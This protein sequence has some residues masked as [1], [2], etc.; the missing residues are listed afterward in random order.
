[1]AK[2]D[3]KVS[4][5]SERNPSSRDPE[6]R[7]QPFLSVLLAG[8]V[9]VPALG[10]LLRIIIALAPEVQWLTSGLAL[11]MGFLL[12]AIAVAVGIKVAKRLEFVVGHVAVTAVMFGAALYITSVVRMAPDAEEWY[13]RLAAAFWWPSWWV[14][15]HLFGSIV[16]AGS[17]LLY[18]IDAFRAATGTAEDTSGLGRLMSRWPKGAKIRAETIE[19]DEFAI[20]AEIDHEGVPIGELRAQLPALEE[21]P[22]FLRGRGSMVGDAKGGKTT[23][24]LVHTDPH[25]HW[26]P[27]PGLSHPGQPYHA[28]LRTSYYSDGKIQWYSFVKTPDGFRSQLAP[29]FASPN[30][31]FK[32]AQGM[33]GAGKSGDAAIECAE[34]L[35]RPDVVL[36]YVDPAK[37]MQNAAWCIDMCALAAGSPQASGV[38]FAGLQRMGEYRERVLSHHEIRDFSHEAF[39]KTGL[40]W[41]HI[42]ADEFDVARQSAAM[43]W[44][45]TKGRSLGFRFSFTLPRATGDNLDTN[46][47]A[48]V[49]MWAQFGI[50]QDYDDTFV[51]SKETR[52]AGADAEQFGAA[53]PGAHYLDHAPGVDKSRWPIDCRTYKTRDDFADLRAAVVAARAGFTPARLTQGELDAFGPEVAILLP[54]RIRQSRAINPADQQKQAQQA[55]PRDDPEPTGGREYGQ[56]DDMDTEV[57]KDVQALMEGE[58]DAD[59]DAAALEAEY[60]SLDTRAPLPDSAPDTIGMPSSKPVV[61]AAETVAEME[62]AIIRMDERNV[63]EFTSAD[64]RAEMRVAMRQAAMSKRFTAIQNDET[65]NP[66]GLLVKRMSSGHFAIV[67]VGNHGA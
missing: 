8:L 43:T 55:P 60:G 1:M 53:V 19:A 24:R 56:E 18:R 62:A 21:S 17:W 44:L 20:T 35:S 37:L 15:I 49:G 11:S 57:D 31:S 2:S 34:V 33:T 7:S 64:L 12:A 38:L 9:A 66:P 13:R 39:L 50:S 63:Q 67:R 6:K 25:S 14:V 65:L 42:F 46:I 59:A 32:G 22:N 45:A 52:E 40:P 41:V 4:T 23:V 26:R 10:L 27:W 61:S 36:I 30:G 58:P 29:D 16:L 5:T 47:R 3:V 28:P 48:A 54:E 51:L